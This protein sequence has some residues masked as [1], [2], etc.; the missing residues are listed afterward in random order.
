MDTIYTATTMP[1][2]SGWV[3][4][5]IVTL[6]GTVGTMGGAMWAF[7]VGRLRK[8]DEVIKGLQADIDRISK[9]CGH[10]ECL[11]KNR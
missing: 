5:I 4:G 1:I 11:W 7:M 2:D 3:L 8:Q 10:S 9:G 6:G